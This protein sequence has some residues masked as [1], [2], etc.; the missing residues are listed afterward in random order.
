MFEEK[1]YRGQTVYK[2]GVNSVEKIYLIKNGDFSLSKQLIRPI[3][4]VEDGK[5]Y[6]NENPYFSYKKMNN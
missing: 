2:E 1:F 4:K 6:F 3:K 5:S